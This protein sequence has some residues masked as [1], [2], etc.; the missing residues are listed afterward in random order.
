[1][2]DRLPFGVK[3]CAVGK[4]AVFGV[5]SELHTVHCTI[6]SWDCRLQ[7]TVYNVQYV[8]FSEQCSVCCDKYEVYKCALCCFHC[9]V[10]SVYC[11][12]CIVYK[13][14]ALFTFWRF[15][16]KVKMGIS[17]GKKLRNNILNNKHFLV[18][19]VQLW[20]HFIKVAML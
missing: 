12:L 15:G 2:A 11:T 16:L 13:C 17:M 9:V 10:N 19:L 14:F 7:R 4:C 5:W 20:Y 18:F 8:R 6:Q 3:K 1:M